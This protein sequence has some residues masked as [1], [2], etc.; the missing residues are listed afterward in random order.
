MAE[1]K[2]KPIPPKMNPDTSASI[3]NSG[4]SW[5]CVGPTMNNTAPKMIKNND[6][7][8]FGL[9][10]SLCTMITSHPAFPCQ[11]PFETS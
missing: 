1:E 5:Y 4:C 2:R 8:L 10:C 6:V 11:S 9:L 7:L 3:P